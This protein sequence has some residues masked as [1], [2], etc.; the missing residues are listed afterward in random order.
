MSQY[1]TS[2][3]GCK[4]GVTLHIYSKQNAASL[5]V[6]QLLVLTRAGFRFG[7]KYHLTHRS[8]TLLTFRIFLDI[9]LANKIVSS[10]G[11]QRVCVAIIKT[12]HYMISHQRGI[13]IIMISHK[14][15]VKLGGLHVFVLACGRRRL[16]RDSA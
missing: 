4:A 5:E 13:G 10:T 8:F 15:S 1:R 2:V 3:F 14:R 16:L 12:A 11:E 9:R 6:T 7:G